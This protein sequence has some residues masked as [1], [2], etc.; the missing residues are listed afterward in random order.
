MGAAGIPFDAVSKG[1]EGL[2]KNIDKFNIERVNRALEDAKANM[3]AGWG[4]GA[5]NLAI[6]RKA[7][8][9]TSPAIAEVGQAALKALGQ[10]INDRVTPLLESMV[11]WAGDAVKAIPLIAGEVERLGSKGEKAQFLRDIFKQ[12]VADSPDA[13][14]ALQNVIKA[15]ESLPPSAE[16]DRAVIQA[17]EGDLGVR[18]VQASKQGGTAISDLFERVKGGSQETADAASKIDLAMNKIKAGFAAAFENIPLGKLSEVLDG[19]ATKV[20]NFSQSI[21][22][23]SWESFTTGATTA[24]TTVN[25]LILTMATNVK[26]VQTSLAQDIWTMFVTGATTALTQ[27]GSMIQQLV[28]IV[29]GIASAFSTAAS[30]AVT[31]IGQIESALGGLI[32]KI[33]EAM[34]ALSNLQAKAAGGA[35]GA[36]ASGG[37]MGGRGTG[38]SDSNLAWLSR[39]E[40]IM[41]ARAVRQP[42]VLALLEALRRSGGNLRGVLDRMGHFAMGGMVGAPAFARGGAVGGMSNVTIQF[43]GVQPITGL[44]ASSA[45]VDELRRSAALGASALGRAQAVAVH[46]MPAHTLL[47]IDAIDFSQWAVRGITMTLEPIDQ[48]AALARDCRGILADISAWRNSGNTR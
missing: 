16:R 34:Q 30:G 26:Q 18:L 42:G 40:H 28:S 11:K 37:I 3:A 2:Q 21:N 4:A 29:Q 44:R 24:M 33:N 13:V 8:E 1:L 45:V 48:A 27:V 36:H 31:A 32:Q 9:S 7:A 22:N 47:S 46:L 41:P 20:Q 12:I 19:A 25:P 17:L 5:E 15:M 14:A 38:T 23:I 6:L 39:G 35:L 10:P 43:P